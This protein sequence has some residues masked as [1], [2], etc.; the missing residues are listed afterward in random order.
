MAQFSSQFGFPE[1]DSA[2][3]AP[4]GDLGCQLVSSFS[5]W[6]A[7][8]EK[9]ES[10]AWLRLVSLGQLEKVLRPRP[11]PRAIK[12]E[13]LGVGPRQPIFEGCAAVFQNTAPGTV[14]VVEWIRI[15]LPMQGT[16]VRFLV[17]EDS[18]GWAATVGRA[19]QRLSP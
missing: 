10:Q 2:F 11:H 8:L 15:Q 1:T 18:T 7:P 17:G 12:S 16:R 19:P 13:P 3:G 5:S 6:W 4:P 9:S 14:L